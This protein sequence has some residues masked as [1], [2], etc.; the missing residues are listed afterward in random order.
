MIKNRE[1]RD[2]GLSSKHSTVYYIIIITMY[3]GP[4]V[5]YAGMWS[6]LI[7]SVRWSLLEF[8]VGLSLCMCSVWTMSNTDDVLQFGVQENEAYI[9]DCIDITV[10]V[11]ESKRKKSRKIKDKGR[12]GEKENFTNCPKERWVCHRWATDLLRIVPLNVA[13]RVKLLKMLIWR[14][15]TTRPVDSL[16]LRI[17]NLQDRKENLSGHWKQ[18][19]MDQLHELSRW[20][21]ISF[22]FFKYLIINK[23]TRR[24]V[25]SYICFQKKSWRT[26]VDNSHGKSRSLTKAW[27]APTPITS[28]SDVLF[29]YMNT[30]CFLL[31]PWRSQYNKIWI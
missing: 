12:L 24:K 7:L 11:K 18:Q 5:M 4:L 25:G 27:A 19:V 1:G 14:H 30:L 16:H 6:S 23:H 26:F 22:L 28:S 3:S 13:S 29:P 2:N 15:M 20:Y 10:Y 21:N 17:W 31:W 8:D 9:Y